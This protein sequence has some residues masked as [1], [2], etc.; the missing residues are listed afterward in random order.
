MRTKV[1]CRVISRSACRSSIGPGESFL[2]LLVWMLAILKG[3]EGP[4]CRGQYIF[5]VEEDESCGE[6]VVQ[7]ITHDV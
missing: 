1:P 5:P 2:N 4:N 6:T 3:D 7:E